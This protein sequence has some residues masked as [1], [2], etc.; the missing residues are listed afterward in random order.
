V[1]IDLPAATPVRSGMFGTARF[2]GPQREGLAVPAG[3][4][5]RNGQ[6]TS[7]FVVDQDGKARLRLVNAGEQVNERVEILAGL[8]PGDRVVVDPPAALADGR[9]VSTPGAGRGATVPDAGRGAA[10]PR[11]GR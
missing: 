10:S 6:L 4:I 11:T 3:A 8:V 7:V 2:A 5:V 1:K 9:A